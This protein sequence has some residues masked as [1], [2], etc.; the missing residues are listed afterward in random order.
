[1]TEPSTIL[2][3]L[4]QQNSNFIEIVL[5]LSLNINEFHLFFPY[6][7]DWVK[8]ELQLLKIFQIFLQDISSVI[9]NYDEDSN[10][11]FHYLA[12]KEYVQS[13]KYLETFCLTR[14]VNLLHQA[15]NYGLTP[16]TFYKMNK[17]AN[18]TNI[19]VDVDNHLNYRLQPN[20]IL[21]FSTSIDVKSIYTFFDNIDYEF[22]KEDS[23]Q[24]YG[25]FLY[26]R[27]QKIDNDIRLTC[28]YNKQLYF[29]ISCGS[30]TQDQA[31]TLTVLF[32]NVYFSVKKFDINIKYKDFVILIND[33]SK[34][35]P[36][37][38]LFKKVSDVIKQ[39]EQLSFLTDSNVEINSIMEDNISFIRK[40][41]IDAD[42]YIDELNKDFLIT[43]KLKSFFTQNAYKIYIIVYFFL[44][45]VD[46][47]D[48]IGLP[49]KL[50]DYVYSYLCL[51][52]NSASKDFNKVFSYIPT[53]LASFEF[54]RMKNIF[55]IN[56]VLDYLVFAKN[57]SSITIETVKKVESLH[58]SF[59]VPRI[60]PTPILEVKD[61]IISSVVIS[62]YKDLILS[63]YNLDQSIE[64]ERKKR[65]FEN[66][67]KRK[68]INSNNKKY[69]YILKDFIKLD[70]NANQNEIEF[71]YNQLD[72]II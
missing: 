49:Y 63:V 70:S 32:N 11:I 23:E 64:E 67:T 68:I 56:Y 47:L 40:L 50:L 36:K 22:K 59:L 66:S 62:K 27:N 53:N 24:D 1:M 43:P 37:L 45:E 14:G 7:V 21:P 16:D 5:F 34:V 4:L 28:L 44:L 17:I 52:E 18:A 69:R 38:L 54:E 61:P 13:I 3:V 9:F 19:V 57:S 39:R 71:L 48:H 55:E 60:L 29:P 51:F 6:I 30:F 58:N 41:T 65:L 31:F 72:A 10:N 8:D 42:K 46:I 26:L 15:N 33:K 20:E 12:K 25:N 35:D 2:K